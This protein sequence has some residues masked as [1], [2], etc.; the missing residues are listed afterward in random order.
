MLRES[1]AGFVPEL[2]VGRDRTAAAMLAIVAR[3][4]EIVGQSLNALPD[5]DRLAFADACANALL[6]ASAA[7]A[8]LV[9]ELL[10]Q[11]PRDLVLPAG[12]RVAARLPQPPPSL[13]GE[14][15]VAMASEAVF[16]TEE[17]II[18][19]RG[20]LAAFYSIDPAADTYTDHLPTIITG[21]EL[22]ADAGP[23]PHELYLGHDEY[24]RLAGT[25][26]VTLS[27]DLRQRGSGPGTR[28][29]ATP[30][31]ARPILLDWA[32]LSAEGWLPLAVQADTTA[33][34]TEDGLVTLRK[35]CGPDAQEGEIAGRKSFWIRA[36][37]SNRR[38]LAR[39]TGVSGTRLSVEE[40]R[41]FL[42]GDEV[43][44][45][46]REFAHIVLTGTDFIILDNPL[47]AA[48]A[49]ARL[50]LADELPPLRS[51]GSDLAGVL[52]QVDV[53]RASVGFEKSGIKPDAAALDTAALPIEQRFLPFGPQPRTTT[54]FF[55]ACKEAFQRKG[56]SVHIRARLLQA[57]VPDLAKLFEIRAQYFNGADWADFPAFLEL[58]GAVSF[59]TS[60]DPAIPP[61]LSFICPEDWVETAVNGVNGLWLKLR[62]AQGD[63]GTPEF[64]V[65]KPTPDTVTVV[66]V[67]G[68]LVPPV[69][70]G[71]N[72]AY[73]YATRPAFLDYCIAFN[74][75]VHADH[76]ED[77]RWPRRPFAPFLPVSDRAPTVHLGFTQPFPIGLVSILVAGGPASQQR[78]KARPLC[79]SIVRRAAG[80][81]FR[82]RTGVPALRGWGSSSLSA[83][84][85]PSQPMGWAGRC[86]GCGRG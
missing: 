11:A 3:Q 80:R 64:T 65:E 36:H 86:I 14:A 85:M 10:D 84:P 22:F 59:F 19:S 40:A 79:S 23:A 60:A 70:D 13:S 17:T 81:S 1:A 21:S 33:R 5:R 38:P 37:V 82:S 9:F 20:K 2:E 56:A 45:D 67:P 73:V 39:I 4:L 50:R 48:Q 43:T 29:G 31:P 8:P 62:L 51:E 42:P 6:P 46:S 55:L 83:H 61:E 57:G 34:L 52:P 41:D 25:A 30:P 35:S 26:E 47:S 63:F 75:F 16:A 77:F 27:I 71:I 54:T 49:G 58:K 78:A 68:K 76:S 24:F 74:D 28:R 15:A 18:L 69:I 66:E 72:I 7:R 53:I 44:V 12:S 32:Y